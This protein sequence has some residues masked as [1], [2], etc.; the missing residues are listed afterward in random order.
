MPSHPH[1]RL[2]RRTFS[3]PVHAV[4]EL[5]AVLPAG[6]VSGLDLAQL[7]LVNGATY[8][9]EAL[10]ERQVDLLY[11]VPITG[12]DSSALVYVLFEHQSSVDSRMPARLLVYM[13][14]IWDQWMREHPTGLLPPVNPVVL[15]HSS[16]GWT[17]STRF[18][19]RVAVPP[20]LRA[21]LERHLPDFVFL[22]DD[23]TRL[24]EAELHARATTAALRLTLSAMRL[25][26]DG[27]P[28][29]LA[30]WASL[31]LETLTEPDGLRAFES[32]LRYLVAVRED[33]FVD[34]LVKA[35][36][37]AEVETIAMTYKERLIEQGR[38][39]G[40]ARGRAKGRAEG[41]RELLSKLLQLKFGPLDEATAERLAA[42]DLELLELW[43]ERV[44]TAERL[45]AVFAD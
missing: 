30:R 5:R 25:G 10:A 15:H 6:L 23:L 35:T 36:N 20:A 22:L 1:D 2:F 14:R 28:A 39:E 8:V 11:S 12:A 21:A 29:E 34:A 24:S 16:S 19:D 32:L 13:A 18:I 38:A 45:A 44:L 7:E 27:Q 17:G 31:L 43:S 26:R 37:D 4:E 41:V 40:E 3:N 33:D 9:D 42:A